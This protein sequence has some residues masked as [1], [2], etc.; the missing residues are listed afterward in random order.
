MGGSSRLSA[1]SSIHFSLLVGLIG[2]GD[3]VGVL[4]HVALH[5]LLELVTGAEGD[6]APGGDGNLLPGLGIA[7]RPRALVAQPEI[8]EARELHL[9]AVHERRAD[10]LEKELH[11]L[12]G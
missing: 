5:P 9:L 8:T 10:L 12:L 2:R 1:G 6:D 7:A 4:A 11:E 3:P